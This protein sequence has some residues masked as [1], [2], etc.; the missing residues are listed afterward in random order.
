MSEQET[1]QGKQV[2]TT[3]EIDAMFQAMMVTLSRLAETID[4]VKDE[5]LRQS[6]QS[7]PTLRVLHREQVIRPRQ[8]YDQPGQACVNCVEENAGEIEF[9]HSYTPAQ[10]ND[11]FRKL[12]WRI[13]VLARDLHV[14]RKQLN[15]QAAPRDGSEA[16]HC[17]DDDD[18]S[19][20]T[21]DNVDSRSAKLM[22]N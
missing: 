22:R 6:L 15:D 13:D 18:T 7:H 21:G 10:L 11:V 9:H 8:S 14:V 20:Q 19:L 1:E 3:S 4:A 17:D 2:Y 12:V 16:V 5:Q